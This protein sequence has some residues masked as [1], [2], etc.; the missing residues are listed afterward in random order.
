VTRRS[1]VARARWWATLPVLLGGCAT[2]T[3][4]HPAPVA[5]SAA[6]AQA[7]KPV[8]VPAPV[9][10]TLPPPKRPVAPAT[11]AYMLGLMPVRGTGVAAWRAAHPTYDGRGVLIG[12]LDSGVDPGV[13]GLQT[14]STGLPKLLDLRN[15][16]S[17][18]PI[19]LAPVRADGAGRITLAGGLV[20][21]GAAAV[22]AVAQDSAWYG[23][24][25]RE[26]SFG[27]APAA[28][29]NGDGS[30]RDSYGVV[31]VRGRAGWVAFVDADGD[32]SLADDKPVADFLV[33]RQTFTFGEP[34]GDR[35]AP[36][37]A[38]VNLSEDASGKPHL[39][40]V[41][42]TAGH[43]THVAGIASGHA[44][45]GVA[46]FDG[47]APGAQIL[48]L[49]IADD[50]RG[51]ISTTGSMV[52]AMDYAARFAAER[53]LPL[54]LN[55]SFGIGNMEPGAAVM[56]SVVDAFL[57]A[58]PDVVFAIAAGNDGP[59]TR[60]MGLPA[61]AALALAVGAVYPAEFSPVQ[62]GTQSPDVLGWW[63][64]R[65][66][67]L[68]KPD[69]V[70]P[71]MAYSTVPEWNTGGE[72]KVGTSMASP[73]A[74][75]LA[76]DL[77]SAALAEGR[78]PTAAQLVQALKVTAHHLRG[79]TETDEGSGM[80]QLEAAWQ[81]LRAGHAAGRY[82]VRALPPA[83]SAAAAS[84][85]RDPSV[86]AAA[87]G[88][89]AAYRRGGLAGP[90]DTLQTFVVRRVA[91]STS[92]NGAPESPTFRLRSDVRWL[93]PV[94]PT[95][96]LDTAGAD[97][98][99]VRYDAARLSRPGRYV[100]A[101]EAYAAD[102]AA[103]PAFRLVSE[104][105]VPDRVAWGT[106]TLADRRLAAGQAWRYYV[107]VPAG[108]ADLSV[109]AVAP[110]TSYRGALSLFEPSGRPSRTDEESD[111]GGRMGVGGELSVTAN[112]LTPGVWEAVVQA[113][114][115]DSLRYDFTAAVPAIAIARVDSTGP[116]PGVTLQSAL[117]RDTTLRVTA[118]ETGIATE[119]RATVENGGPYRRTFDAPAWATQAI[120]EVQ[121]TPG[122]W[123]LV[124]DFGL[125]FFDKDGAQLGNSPMNYDFNRLVVDLPA[126]RGARFP[127]TAE[128]FPAFALPAPPASFAADVRVS[129]V[130]PGRAIPLGEQGDTATVSLTGFGTAPVGIPSFDRRAPG[131]GWTDLVRLRVMGRADDWAYIERT[132]PIRHP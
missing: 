118:D 88:P 122:F 101:V 120:L 51:G 115:G 87:G 124:T 117:P 90:W 18:G 53:H 23:G 22:A 54:V 72:I 58:H 91:D 41:L 113:M 3:P 12:I 5:P 2:T 93:A 82:L 79:E 69:V 4:P 39:S 73:Y 68:D 57:V 49:K 15:F 75:G 10:A 121:L 111:F 110:D 45:G 46:G 42:D 55:M 43:G 109:R 100:G 105:I 80:P 74:A 129:F 84:A 108:A 107:N 20:L 62:F 86:R 21:S 61:S 32:G 85:V 123:N 60:T 59:G 102:S 38:A 125:T 37:T 24:V 106:T 25:I 77:L 70:T 78:S 17:E 28:D 63:S 19:P 97:T 128:L 112:D 52:E 34:G 127:V 13:A 29:F 103:G 9:P 116:S 119:W 14:T 6:P 40:L 114:P 16:S 132:V 99:V 95:A 104:V 65:G 47:I 64:S 131:S 81:W 130:G 66:G 31:V 48:A 26:L 33:Q 89:S 98:I 30:N 71:G 8:P 83:D 11:T 56:D 50:A 27:D 44:I 35:P 67:A 76:A 1:A 7:A 92:G 36:I 94:H 126:K 96:V